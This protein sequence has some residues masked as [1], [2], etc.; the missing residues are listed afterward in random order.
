MKKT[1]EKRKSV[2]EREWRS[3][4]KRLPEPKLP[5]NAVTV[6]EQRYLKKNEKGKL[7]ESPRDLFFRVARAVATAEANYGAGSEL[8]LKQAEKFYQLMS[9]RKFMP[10]S[11][12]LMNAGREMGLLSACFVL[13]VEDSIGGIFDSLKAT[14]LIQKAG[15]GTGFA[16]DALRPTGDFVTTSGGATSGP[17]SFWKVFSEATNAIQQGAFRRGAN[18]GMMYIHHPDILKFIHAKEDLSRF[19]NFNISVKVTDEFMERLKKDRKK[20]HLVRNPRTGLEYYLP[21]DLSI[22]DYRLQD[23]IEAVK[24]KKRPKAEVWS[25]GDIF[26]KIIDCAWRSGEPGMVFT[27]RVNEANPTPHLGRIEATNP[28]GEQPLLPYEACNLGSINL[29]RFVTADASAA[30]PEFN[31]D[32]LREVVRTGTRFLDNVIDINRYPLD[33]IRD[34]CLGNRKIGL[35]IMGFADALFR[36]AIPYNSQAG[37]E[38]GGKVM[39]FINDESHQMSEEL[40]EERCAFPFW[41]GSVWDKKHRRKMR[42]ATTTTV[43]PTGTISIIA[44][45]SS[46]VEPLFSLAFYRNVLDGKRLTEVNEHFKLAAETGGYY[47]EKLIEQLTEQG[48]VAEAETVPPEAK[49]V[50]VCAH[51]VSPDWHIKMQAAFQAHNDSAISKTINFPHDATREDVYKLF[52][53]AF[54]SKVKGVTVYRDGCRDNQ[55][56]A[57]DSKSAGND[58]GAGKG[59]AKVL[60]SG[61]PE[62]ISAVRVRQSTPFGHMHLSITVDPVN[63]RELE[64]FAQL[65][66]GGDVAASDLEAICR[67]VSLFLRTGGELE[68]V[69]EQLKGIGSSLSIPTANGRIMSL[70]DGI[71]TALKRYLVAKEQVG[72]RAILMGEFVVDESAGVKPATVGKAG[73]ASQMDKINTAYKIACPQCGGGLVF[74]EGCNKCHGCGYSTC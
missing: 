40:A 13:P 45:C 39:R 48:S 56:M 44:N 34:I 49:Q 26:D 18:M 57:L 54:D 23:L 35:G 41:E 2:S 43:A 59:Q 51:D 10:N 3:L 53:M 24:G 73:R 58:A 66:K 69:I 33:E 47:S 12:T 9:E 25:C 63:E 74:E 27:D 62:I 46:G 7:L 1:I 15:G 6:L 5:A 20:P 29:E 37:I 67:M 71:A 55:P 38:F 72:L 4:A 21:R 17:I 68:Q 70:G 61:T 19:T 8:V 65:G 22:E 32:G 16:F 52:V 36:L 60:P 28:C 64:V 42:N 31:W 50:F 11:P 14:A 30:E